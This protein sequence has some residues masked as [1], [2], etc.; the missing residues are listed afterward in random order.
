MFNRAHLNQ[1]LSP[2]LLRA[3]RNYNESKTGNYYY[4]LQNSRIE[5]VTNGRT[6]LL[7]PL[8]TQ[9]DDTM[10]M[11]TA[12]TLWIEN[13]AFLSRFISNRGEI[14]G[15]RRSLYCLSLK[16]REYAWAA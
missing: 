3:M 13:G 1:N 7:N 9:R 15:R 4:S 12:K 5:G 14:K 8:T 10:Q 6:W 2:A 11:K 16:P